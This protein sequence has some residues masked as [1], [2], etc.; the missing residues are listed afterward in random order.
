MAYDGYVAVCLGMLV[1][2]Q[3]GQHVSAHG[4]EVSFC[5]SGQNQNFLC[6][7][8]T[9]LLLS[10]SPIAPN[11][12]MITVIDVYFGV[13]NFLLTM[14]SHPLHHRQPLQHPAHP[15][16]GGQSRRP[17][18]RAPPACCW[19]ACTTPPSP[20]PG[21]RVLLHR[22][23]HLVCVYC[24][25][26]A[27]A[28]SACTAPRLAGLRVLLRRRLRLVCVYCSAVAYAWSACT[29]PPSPTP[30]LRVLLRRRLHLHPP[31]LQ[32]LHGQQHSGGCAVH[33]GQPHPEPLTYS[34]R[35]KD[36]TVALRRVCSCIG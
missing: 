16:C 13:V 19:S 14:V 1:S 5:G 27:Y 25:A 21:L 18:P 8:P 9:L 7:V 29:A 26:V 24:S 4:P 31:G 33:S 23:L 17:S 10:C 12:I 28:W 35:N 11:N 2:G 15:H 32:L 6:E 36:V 22:R 20:T 34:L 3:C 30:G